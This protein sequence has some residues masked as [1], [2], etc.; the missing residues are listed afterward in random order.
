MTQSSRNPSANTGINVV[1][2]HDIILALSRRKWV[3]LFL[4]VLA[5]GLCFWILK[6]KVLTYTSQAS[7]Y[8]SEPA[9]GTNVG[10][11]QEFTIPELLSPG[12]QYDRA[13]QLIN[14]SKV[15]EHLIKKFNLLKYY[16]IDTTKE[17]HYEKAIAILESRITIK[18]SPNNLI[19]IFISDER[20]YLAADMAN[21]AITYLDEINK[22]LIVKTMKQ[23]LEIFETMLKNTETDNAKR[24]IFFN[25]Q[26]SSLNQTL[27]RIE[28]QEANSISLLQLQSQL[29]QLISSLERSSE[30]VMRMRVNYSLALQAVQESNLP[31]IVVIHKARPSHRSI[32][33]QS[34][35]ISAIIMFL[36]FTGIV[37]SVYIKLRY[38][39]YF[40]VLMNNN[41]KGADLELKIERKEA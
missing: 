35:L 28:K 32:G 36:V 5:G 33:L 12:Q 34:L 29:S 38:N 20:R 13:F 23:R 15:H 27:S 1:S 11:N 19:S 31:S 17:F 2:N 9:G 24:S 7:F 22:K 39:N 40:K 21:E 4:I 6:Y 8:I 10:Q 37:Y 18:K 26:M 41:L 3:Y 30:E 14:S 25:T 16:N